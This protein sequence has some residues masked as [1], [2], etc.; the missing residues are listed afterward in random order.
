MHVKKK[1]F[2]SCNLRVAV[3][4][5]AGVLGSV[6]EVLQV[7]LHLAQSAPNPQQV[8]VSVTE[9]RLCFVDALPADFHHLGNA[10]KERKILLRQSN[11][12]I[13]NHK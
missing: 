11:V 6:V 13:C 7:G 5:F 10:F 9:N 8:D 12:L 1:C 4:H 3:N 2:A